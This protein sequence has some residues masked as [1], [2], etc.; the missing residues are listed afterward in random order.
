MD[1]GKEEEFKNSIQSPIASARWE[2]SV[3][4]SAQ[5]LDRTRAAEEETLREDRCC[6]IDMILMALASLA[7]SLRRNFTGRN[8]GDLDGSRK[9]QAP[10]EVLVSP[11]AHLGVCLRAMGG[12][13][14]GIGEVE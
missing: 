3:M 12:G 10:A 14:G 2:L 4:G 6:R 8:F 1:L 13:G 9:E 11:A 5:D 7:L